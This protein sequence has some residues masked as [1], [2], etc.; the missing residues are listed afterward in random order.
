MKAILIKILKLI[1]T[2]ISWLV[3][4]PLFYFLHYKWYRPAKAVRRIFIFLSPI[5]LFFILLFSFF[6]ALYVHDYLYRG[7]HWDLK[8][9]TEV[10]FPRYTKIQQKIVY[11]W[12]GYRS[13]HGD[14]GFSY[15]A[16]FDSIDAEDFYNQIEE[17]I[18]NPVHYTDS[19]ISQCGWF[20]NGNDEYS[21]SLIRQDPDYSL[22]VTVKKKSHSIGVGW[23]EW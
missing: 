6:G 19:L 15:H 2:L 16:S 20:R 22:S 10:S 12:E 11:P 1:S 18:K 14:F 23:G 21:F 17:K 9:T 8:K 5:I 13:F 4:P 7:S 3:L